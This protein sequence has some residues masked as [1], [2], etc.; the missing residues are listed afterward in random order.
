MRIGGL[1]EK[2]IAAH[3]AGCTTVIIPKENQRDLVEIPDTVRKDIT[4]MPVTTIDE[5]LAIALQPAKHVTL[6]A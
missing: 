5:V 4:F 1:K 6:E 3:Q 2:S